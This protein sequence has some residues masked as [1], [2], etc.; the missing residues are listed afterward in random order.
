MFFRVSNRIGLV[1]ANTVEKTEEQLKELFPP[2]LW[3]KAH[4]LIIFHGRRVCHARKP[5]CEECTINKYCEKNF[6]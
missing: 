2:E 6:D 4:H 1:K 3:I 5:N